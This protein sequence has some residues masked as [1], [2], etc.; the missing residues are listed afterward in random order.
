[1]K[2]TSRKVPTFGEQRRA[3]RQN[4]RLQAPAMRSRYATIGKLQIDLSFTG[5][6]RYG[7]APGTLPP[8]YDSSADQYAAGTFDYQSIDGDG[9]GMAYDWEI[10]NSFNPS[11]ADGSGDADA[12]GASNLAEYLAGTNPRSATSIFRITSIANIAGGAVRLTFT[13]R[14]NRA[15]TVQRGTAIG[16]WT[17]IGIVP[18]PASDQVATFDDTPPGPK[19]F[20]RLKAS[21]P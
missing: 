11:V 21:G 4:D 13:A 18:A 8:N 17:D 16:T 6:S 2:L 12:D 7:G 9:D 14:A 15:Y 1:M 3:G 19:Q 10:A 20:Y 5:S